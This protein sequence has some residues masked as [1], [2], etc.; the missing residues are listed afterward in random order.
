MLLSWRKCH[1]I[2]EERDGRGLSNRSVHL[3]ANWGQF[4]TM[5]T[6]SSAPAMFSKC[7]TMCCQRLPLRALHSRHHPVS[8]ALSW[9]RTLHLRSMLLADHC[10][11][12]FIPVCKRH[13]HTLKAFLLLVKG[14]VEQH[15]SWQQHLWSQKVPLGQHT[16][17]LI[18]KVTSMPQWAVSSWFSCALLHASRTRY[19]Y[20]GTSS[21]LCYNI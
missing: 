15:W 4:P 7:L 11:S 3:P 19:R 21:A 13:K 1:R 20:R 10:S 5:H 12:S 14:G 2:T 6:P 8:G 17:L 16:L 18:R 9:P